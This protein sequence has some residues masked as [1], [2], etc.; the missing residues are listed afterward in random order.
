MRL[1][2]LDTNMLKH[3]MFLSDFYPTD[4]LQQ[5]D[6]MKV[7]W[8]EEKIKKKKNVILYTE[9]SQQHLRNRIFATRAKH[10][11]GHL[12]GPNLGNFRPF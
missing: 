11:F 8:K 3:V 7:L 9:Q 1:A 12:L 10:N 6:N 2:K 4:Q 5:V